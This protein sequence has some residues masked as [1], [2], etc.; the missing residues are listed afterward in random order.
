MQELLANGNYA[1]Y[2]AQALTPPIVGAA[3]TIGSYGGNPG[4]GQQF[5]TPGM[6]NPSWGNPAFGQFG[7]GLAGQGNS[8]NLNVLGALGGQNIFGQQGF[9]QQL[10]QPQQHQIAAQQQQI[11]T[12]LHQLAHHAAVNLA[13]GQQVTS[14][15]Q[16]IAQYC[17]SQMMTG[18]QAVQIL[19]QLAH[20]SA[21]LAQATRQGGLGQQAI[22]GFGQPL[23]YGGV[24]V[25]PFGQQ[26]WGMGFNRPL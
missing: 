25:A 20:Q 14:T 18:Y 12:V 16:Q 23:G 8:G 2:L 17:A 15:L 3:G 6:S 22:Y 1:P 26:Q 5:G 13:V 10:G 21:W 9:G 24:N 11:A 7:Q 4:I 19:N